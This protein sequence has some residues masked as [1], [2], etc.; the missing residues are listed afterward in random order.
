[1][2]V[3]AYFIITLCNDYCCFIQFQKCTYIFLLLTFILPDIETNECTEHNG[4]CWQDIKS[5]ITACKVYI[6]NF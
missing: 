3:D 2:E 5:N 1:V 4:G 6:Q